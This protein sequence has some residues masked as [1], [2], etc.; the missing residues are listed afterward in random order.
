M[1]CADLI[2]N[3]TYCYNSHNIAE[4]RKNQILAKEIYKKYGFEKRDNKMNIEEQDLLK[5]EVK[6]IHQTLRK[7]MYSLTAMSELI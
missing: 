3:G 5:D 6:N 1:E 4:W 2:R 7:V